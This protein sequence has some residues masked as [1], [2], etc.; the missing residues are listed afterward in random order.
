PARASLRPYATLCR[1][2]VD[3][4]DPAFQLVGG[5]AGDVE[6]GAEVL[7][8]QVG[9]RIDLDDGGS[10]ERA[11]L[12]ARRQRALPDPAARAAHLREVEDRKSTRLNSSHVKT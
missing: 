9:D 6:H 10:D 8:V 7:P 11:A 5:E 12:A 1:S 3:V 4:A 2:G